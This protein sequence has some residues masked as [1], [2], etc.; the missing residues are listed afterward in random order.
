MC[1]SL[2]RFLQL[3]IAISGENLAVSANDEAQA[4]AEAAEAAAAE[5]E[6]QKQL[7]LQIQIEEQRA[8]EERK[9][10]GKP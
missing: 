7:Q 1:L 10:Q 4:N 6:R 5:A 3:C 8:M 9:R 2:I